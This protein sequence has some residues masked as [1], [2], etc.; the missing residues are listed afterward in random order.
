MKHINS[1]VIRWGAVGV[2]FFNTIDHLLDCI[3]SLCRIVYLN[4]VWDLGMVLMVPFI[5][6]LFHIFDNRCEHLVDLGFCNVSI[7]RRRIDDCIIFF[8]VTVWWRPWMFEIIL[9]DC[10]T[11]MFI[12]NM[13]WTSETTLVGICRIMN[14]FHGL[15]TLILC[16]T[17]DITSDGCISLWFVCI[18]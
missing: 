11:Y 18:P 3:K 14:H 15:V 17:A 8:R 13:F 1:W 12:N 16:Q 9:H 7:F 5:W 4:S 2:I 10:L 6:W